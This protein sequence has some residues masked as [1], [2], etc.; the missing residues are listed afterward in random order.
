MQASPMSPHPGSDASKDPGEVH[1]ARSTPWTAAISSDKLYTNTRATG[2]NRNE[3]VSKQ[4]GKLSIIC[5]K[6]FDPCLS[7]AASRDMMSHNAERFQMHREK[8]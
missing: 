6:G 1:A 3:E 8:F 2:R 7:M 5:T 4:R